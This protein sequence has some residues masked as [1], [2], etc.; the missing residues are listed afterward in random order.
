MKYGVIDI[1]S[2]SVRLMISSGDKTLYKKV[3]TTR[4]A[5]GMGEELMLKPE[6]IE[7]TANAVSF[8]KQCAIDDGA[9]EVYAFATASVRQAHNGYE[10]CDKVKQLC[11]L[12]VE[13]ISGQTEAMLGAKGA[14]GDKDGAIIDVG[15]AS[16]EITVVKNG[17]IVFCKSIDL[18]VV[19][20]KDAVGQD[21]DK[22]EK[23]V[24]QKLIEFGC[25]PESQFYGIGG[26]ATSIAGILL[27]LEP[28]DPE[29]VDGYCVTIESLEK[30]NN[31]LFSMTEQQKRNL[32][33]LQPE[34]AGVIAGGCF[35][36]LQILQMTNSKRVTVSEKD[37]L[38]GYLLYKLENNEKKN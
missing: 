8:F 20:I 27:E 4:L 19:K 31:K 34:R 10:F 21:Y 16:T 15:G 9:N 25:V 6:A 7:R 28:Y 33:G 11:G 5:E 13:V 32:K 26:T 14:L 29:K 30:L 23:L 24:K 2:N 1:G 18:G 35:V 36:V 37:N 38:E 22:V 17:K 3:K 12:N